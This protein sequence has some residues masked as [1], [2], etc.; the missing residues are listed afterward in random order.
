M[1]QEVTWRDDQTKRDK[2]R[3]REK[4]REG[5][6]SKKVFPGSKVVSETPT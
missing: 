5:D 6:I 3:E 1:R 4:E 2:E